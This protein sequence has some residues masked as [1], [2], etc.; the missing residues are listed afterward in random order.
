MSG[1]PYVAEIPS[2]EQ[3][4]DFEAL[5][6]NKASSFAGETPEVRQLRESLMTLHF[7]SRSKFTKGET[8]AGL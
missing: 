4:V 8:D 5:S 3:V 7:V 2:R 6:I 1:G